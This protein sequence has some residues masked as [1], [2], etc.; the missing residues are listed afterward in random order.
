MPTRMDEE[1]PSRWIFTPTMEKPEIMPESI[2]HVFRPLQELATGRNDFCLGG[3]HEDPMKSHKYDRNFNGQDDLPERRALQEE[4]NR[5]V[6]QAHPKVD[7]RVTTKIRAGLSDCP[8][9]DLR[10]CTK[11]EEISV[12]W[13]AL[14]SRFFGEAKAMFDAID[15]STGY[16][17]LLRS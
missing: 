9:P 13:Q 8:L 2:A 4:Y 5:K 1:D 11:K 15:V 17:S 14:C 16:Q 7:M 10:I 6:I 12:N 3:L